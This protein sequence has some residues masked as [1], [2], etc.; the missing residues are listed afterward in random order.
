MRTRKLARGC[1]LALLL[2]L[3]AG[4]AAVAIWLVESQGSGLTG[5]ACVGVDYYAFSDQTVLTIGWYSASAAWSG[6]CPQVGLCQEPPVRWGPI[7]RVGP[8]Y[9]TLYIPPIRSPSGP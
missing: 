4:C 3:C 7:G 5:L 9:G 1:L 6:R 2:P 8:R